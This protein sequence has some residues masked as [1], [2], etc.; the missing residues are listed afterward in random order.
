MQ[1]RSKHLKNSTETNDAPYHIRMNKTIITDILTQTFKPKHLEVIDESH[2]HAH[3]RGTPH[4][5]NTHFHII[6]VSNTF[7]NQS[8][9]N[10]HR[11]INS[12]LN[13]GFKH[14]LH[15]LKIT[16]KTPSEWDQ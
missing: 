8:L 9:I 2:L 16:A 6:I 4:T 15:A 7:T 3:H 14:Q 12:A 13:E 10:R 1:K 5:E 11:A